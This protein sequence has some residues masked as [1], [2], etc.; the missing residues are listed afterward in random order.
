MVKNWLINVANG[1]Q[2]HR[3]IRQRR[4][5]TLGVQSRSALLLVDQAAPVYKNA[6]NSWEKQIHYIT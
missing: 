5:V 3:D 4:D 6:L 2:G 1:S